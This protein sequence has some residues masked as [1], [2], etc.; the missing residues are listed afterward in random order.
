MEL[1]EELYFAKIVNKTKTPLKELEEIAVQMEG[2][3]AFDYVLL[4]ELDNKKNALEERLLEIYE[5]IGV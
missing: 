1:E 2:E 5:E 4:A 3:A